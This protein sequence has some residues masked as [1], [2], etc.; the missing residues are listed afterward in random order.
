MTIWLRKWTRVAS[1]L[2][3][4]A[5]WE[6]SS[7]LGLTNP[8]L[9]AAPSRVFIDIYD[10][11]ASRQLFGALAASMTR[12]LSGFAI[13][14][15]VGVVLGIIMA[16]FRLVEDFVDPLVE[17]IRPISPLAIL[18][19]AILWFGIGDA[20]KI[21]LIALSCTFPILL[22]TYAG[23]KS[24]DASLVRAARSLGANRT[25]IIRRVILPG[26][27]PTI[28]TGVRISWGI[29]LIVIIA[30]EMVGAINGLGFMVLDAQQ[31]FKVERVFSGI[32]VIGVIG[33]VTDRLLRWVRSVVTPWHAEY[34]A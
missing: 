33:F 16:S 19:L 28:L 13:A 12:V 17:L 11:I 2:V 20:S 27:L 6:T 30:S 3:V 23:V 29:A 31:T 26:S 25:E 4:L 34:R 8:Y 9:L 18:P 14:V 24:I 5:L 7:R 32:F 1:P 22:N 15:V 10:L 21:F